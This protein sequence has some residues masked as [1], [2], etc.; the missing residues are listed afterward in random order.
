MTNRGLRELELFGGD[1][2]ITRAEFRAYK[3]DKRYAEASEAQPHRRGDPRRRLRRR[4]G[5]ARRAAAAAPRLVR[6]GRGRRPGRGARDPVGHA[7]GRRAAARA[8]SRRPMQGSYRAAVRTLLRHHGRLDV[9]WGEVNRFRRGTL[10]LPASGGPDVLRAIEDFELEPRRHLH[11]ALGRLARD[12]R[13]V[14]P[15]RRASASRRSTSSAAPR[16]TST[17]RTTPTRR[18]SSCAKRRRPSR[19][20]RPSCGRSSS[21][22]TG[23]ASRQPAHAARRSAALALRRAARGVRRAGAGLPVRRLLRRLLLPEVLDRRAADRAGHGG[24]DLRARPALG[25]GDG[26]GDRRVERPHALAARP[27]AAVDAARRADARA[28]L[29]DDLGP[30]GR[31]HRRRARGL[32]GCGPA[33]LLH[34][35]HVLHRA[36]PL[37]RHGAHAASP[38]AQ[39]RLRRVPGGP[40]RGHDGRVRGDPVRGGRARRTRRGPHAR[41][42]RRR[43]D[44]R[45]AARHAARS[46]AS[47]RGI[48]GAEPPRRCARSRTSPAIRTRGCCC[49]PSSS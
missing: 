28:H 36:A 2:S 45:A 14:G 26:S 30:A 49:S 13:R 20:T 21:A 3:F 19:W 18:R 41:R 37:A 33:P 46:C 5:A 32:D 24:R 23:R 12:V 25:R 39:H 11:R 31:P 47:R 9:P 4:S 34:R 15:R 8:S 1:T 27:A 17:R 29:L 40:D 48:R 44:G 10:D 22:T 42:G 43:R 6:L 38:R 7:R 16:S 35:V